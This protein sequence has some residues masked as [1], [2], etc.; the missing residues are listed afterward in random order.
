MEWTLFLTASM[1]RHLKTKKSDV[2]F[3]ERS[4]DMLYSPTSPSAMDWSTHYPAFI[5]PSASTTSPNT[6]LQ[7]TKRVEIA[8]V[9]CGFGGLLVALSPLLP[10][11]LILGLELRTQVTDYVVNRVAALRSQHPGS[12]G[13]VSALRTNAMKFLPNYFS[14][15][16]LGKIFLCFPDP[17]FK[18]RKHKARIVS[19][20]LNAEYAYVLREGGKVYTITDVEEL[21]QWIAKHFEGEEV[22]D[23]RELWERVQ[24][25]D[26]EGDECVRVMREET[27]EGRKVSRNGGKK[28][29]GVWRRSG[30]PAW[31]GE[32]EG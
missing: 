18:A 27:E 8:D 1:F 16:Q 19:A 11:T 2:Q 32:G 21:G 6:P 22:G 25:E 5:S 31:I 17:H 12:Y 26:L 13:N 28:F 30:D 9:G 20:Q 7:L 23:G 24:G 4:A 29:V 14:R 10:T 3:Q 15:G